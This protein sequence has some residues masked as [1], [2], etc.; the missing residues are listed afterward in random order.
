[1][2]KTANAFRIM[3]ILSIFLTLFS[4][5]KNDE[6]ILDPSTGSGTIEGVVYNISGQPM[7]GVKV[8]SGLSSAISD[9]KGKYKLSNLATNSKTLVNYSLNGY[10]ETQKITS[11]KDNKKSYL[12]AALQAYQIQSELGVSG[13]TIANSSFKVEFPANAFIDS[14]GNAFTGKVSVYASHFNPTDEKFSDAFP[15]EFFGRRN[16][17]SITAIE[18]FGFI[19]VV[20]KNGDEKINLAPGKK[21]KI[22]VNLPA[23]IS[24]RAPQSIPLWYY[25][26]TKGEWIEEGAATLTGGTKYVGEVAHFTSW[27]CDQPQNTSFITGTVVDVEGNPIEHAKVVT[28]G[29]DYTGSYSAYTN[30]KGEFKLL[31]RSNST[32]RVYGI[33][34]GYLTEIK[35]EATAATA[36]EKNI[37]KLKI[38]I[39]DPVEGWT[40]IG[41]STGNSIL[42]MYFISET[43]GWFTN[44]EGLYHTTNSGT[45][46][47]N[48]Y[49]FDNGTG[50]GR[51][52]IF[53]GGGPKVIFVDA[54][55]GFLLFP[56][57]SKDPLLKTTDAGATWTSFTPKSGAQYFSDMEIFGSRLFLQNYQSIFVSDDAGTTW[58]EKST[59]NQQAG[60]LKVFD[61]NTIYFNTGSM[62]LYSTNAGDSWNSKPLMSAKEKYAYAIQMFSPQVFIFADYTGQI[63]RTEDGGVTFSNVGQISVGSAYQS[64]FYFKNANEGWMYGF[65]GPR[66]YT[67]DAGKTWTEVGS[68]A[69]AIN[70][71]F[72]ISDQIGWMCGEGGF[73]NFTNSG[74]K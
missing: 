71:V 31:V 70:K 51:D 29:V 30:E 3:I 18:S 27:N 56:Y 42:D 1:M 55:N 39:T 8:S 62:M 21:A 15:G 9:S 4:C 26:M 7:A 35:I 23:T 45:N 73:F 49:K 50:G 74:A 17:N 40:N 41:I 72:F 10:S 68:S 65:Q 37:G 25:D 44:K 63:Y 33:F 67:N 46:W 53:E 32:A 28:V 61:K 2:K 58:T 36:Q 19:D 6:D 24:S 12:D 64:K 11:V 59:G 14:K 69:L 48:I 38:K 60:D 47:T 13:G 16:D 52:S 54:S 57:G 34:G 20:L 66:L 5:K 43:E 22:T